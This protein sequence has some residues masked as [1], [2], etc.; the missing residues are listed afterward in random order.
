MH[1]SDAQYNAVIALPPG[2]RYSYSIKVIADQAQ[3]W[4]LR[5]QVWATCRDDAEHIWLPLWPAERYARACATGHWNAHVPCPIEVHSLL[6]AVLPDLR[7]HGVTLGVFPTPKASA[8]F[9]TFEQ[10]ESD[11]R[12]ELERIE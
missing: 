8:M 9:P 7:Q 3:A 1:I 11:L 12:Q 5:D 2:K 4:V 10:F 6:N